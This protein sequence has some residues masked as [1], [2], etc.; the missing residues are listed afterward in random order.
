VDRKII[1]AIALARRSTGAA[2]R[3]AAFTGEVDRNTPIS[4]TNATATAKNPVDV[5]MTK[6][7]THSGAATAMPI[8][9]A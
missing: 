8:A 6:H 7:S 2:R 1:V 9:R 3:Q 5:G 4:T